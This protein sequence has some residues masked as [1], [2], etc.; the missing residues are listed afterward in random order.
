MRRGERWRRG[1]LA[2]VALG[3]G[4][5]CSTLESLGKFDPLRQTKPPVQP[6][7]RVLIEIPVGLPQIE[8]PVMDP[9]TEAGLELGRKLFYDKSLSA[10]GQVSCGSCHNPRYAFSDNQPLATGVGGKTHRRHTPTLFNVAY[11]KSFFWDGR[12]ATLEAQAVAPFTNPEEMGLTEAIL[13]QRLNDN[14]IY[15]DLFERNFGPGPI[16]LQ[17][18]GRA[19]ATFERRILSGH[20]L[21]DKFNS[22]GNRRALSQTAARGL[23][24]FVNRARCAICHQLGKEYALF[25][26]GLYHN[27]GVGATAQ[28]ELRDL[29]RY[30]ATKND[31]DRGAFKTPTLRNITQ[32]RPYMHDGSIASL[33]DVIEF[34]DRGGRPNRYQSKLIRPLNLSAQDKLDLLAFMDGLA[35]VPVGNIGPPEG[36]Q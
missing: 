5:G 6:N 7:Q 3:V 36:E 25:T 11:G 24:L 35:G 27:L 34:Y 23:D 29:G 33:A 10:D 19:L 28:G 2:V 12:A 4:C 21:F 17:K 30:E 22:L 20:S 14:S 18:V 13:L 26:D 32:T 15:R 8:Y 31:A 9:P 1:W 16:S